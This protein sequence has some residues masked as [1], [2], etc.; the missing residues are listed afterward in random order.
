ML[1]KNFS[2]SSYSIGVVTEK[3]FN[4]EDFLHSIE[5]C[6]RYRVHKPITFSHR[7]YF[8]I[9]L[10]SILLKFSDNSPYISS[11]SIANLVDYIPYGKKGS[12][13]V[14]AK[15]LAKAKSI[16]IQSDKL[17]DFLS[18]WGKFVKS[19][20]LI[21]GG[22]D[23]N[24]ISEIEVPSKI[25]LVLL[26][27]SAISDNKQ[28]FTLPLGLED[29]HLGRAGLKR[30]HKL[31]GVSKISERI[32]VPPM[33]PTNAIRRQIIIRTLM[34][35]ELFEV[36][37]EMMYEKEYFEIL[38]DYQFVLCLEGNGF[39]VHRM[40]ETLYCGSFPVMLRTT[41]SESLKYL[42]LPILYF[43]EV[44][45]LTDTKLLEFKRKNSDFNPT[46]H[47]FLWT[48]H[49]EEVIKG[50]RPFFGVNE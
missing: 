49:W 50:G 47:Q 22:T 3:N 42:K 32:L 11:R 9:Y 7:R 44:S 17:R 8:Q 34:K 39:D 20:I 40:W 29:R 24:F 30:Y 12:K 21:S 1:T 23:Q 25:R 6:E 13:K 48:T 5:A 27:N 14:N 36:K 35:P 16:F 37:T 15:R 19:D 10:R 43:S 45:D 26:Q 46:K 38:K 33:S 4:D 41:W 2:S 18:T 31:K 28:I